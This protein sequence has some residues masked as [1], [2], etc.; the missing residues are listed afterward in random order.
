[1]PPDLD[2]IAP[3]Q[4]QFLD[5]AVAALAEDGRIIPLRLS[6]F[7]EMV[8]D[9]PWTPATLKQWGGFKGLGVRFLEE[10]FGSNARNPEY[11]AF[12]TTAR[13]IL[14]ALL[15]EAGLAIK[16]QMQPVAHL[17]SAAGYSE[18]STRLARL[19]EILDGELHLIT[20]TEADSPLESADPRL[21]PA[22]AP[23]CYQLSHD[24]LVASLR[25]WLFA[26]QRETWRGRAGIC[27]KERTAEWNRTRHRRSLP[28]FFEY[29]TIMGGVSRPSR[30][31]I[32]REMLSAAGRRHIPRWGAGCLLA[33][34]IIAGLIQF[35][36]AR[37]KTVEAQVESLIGASA[38]EVPAALDRLKSSHRAALPLLRTRMTDSPAESQAELHALYGLAALGDAPL[39]RLVKA[40]ASAPDGECANLIDALRSGGDAAL[41]LLREDAG[42]LDLRIRIRRAIVLW[43]LGVPQA[44]RELCGFGAD[45]SSRIEFYNAFPVWH[46]APLDIAERL[47]G[48]GFEPADAALRSGLCLAVGGLAPDELSVSAGERLRAALAGFYEKAPDSASH[49]AAGLALTRWGVKLP[50]IAETRHDPADRGWYHTRDGL[51]MV[52]VLAGSFLMGET[53]NAN[54]VTHPVKL[55]KG[56]FIAN[57]EVPA[58]LLRLFLRDLDGEVVREQFPFLRNMPRLEADVAAA[59]VPWECAV[60]FCNWLSRREAKQLCYRQEPAGNGIPEG[61]LGGAAGEWTCDFSADGYRLPTEAEWEYACRAGTTTA[62]SFGIGDRWVD[63][64]VVN[65]RNS[66]AS[67]SVG[68]LRPPNNWGLFDL[69]GNVCEWCWD[70]FAPL[71][72]DREQVD[73][74][75]PAGGSLRSLRGGGFMFPATECRSASRVGHAPSMISPLAGVRLVCTLPD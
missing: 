50:P 75:G 36:A 29:C 42:D 56:F 51:V 25:Q 40:I 18:N 62:Y 24:Y 31:P 13:A 41:A 1:L 55:T 66:G 43:H 9:Q 45:A 23:A 11:R 3:E 4:R 64:H 20:P 59:N 6:L 58:S 68:G 72:G 16:G 70:W 28:T 7:A 71:S 48:L 73:P 38:A 65:V 37:Q 69:H 61:A 47:D 12:R 44:A 5:A 27:L 35:L 14:E 15:P 74:R 57:R 19:L 21:E 54:S 53:G 52:R 32:E 2:D 10:T 8:K 49:S 34:M 30:L 17:A 33:G 46:G 63:Q 60:L 39:D 22:P 26:Q 67:P